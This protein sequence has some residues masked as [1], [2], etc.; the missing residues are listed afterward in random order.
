MAE[1]VDQFRCRGIGM[2]GWH[3]SRQTLSSFEDP[4]EAFRRRGAHFTF[5]APAYYQFIQSLRSPT[6]ADQAIPF[7]T[8]SHSLK[9]P[10][11][12]EQPIEP[13]D[14]LVL[15]EGLYVLLDISPWSEAA[16][17]LDA[18]IW[19]EADHTLTR[20]RL[21]RRHI[22]TGV[23]QTAS[24]AQNRVDGSDMLNAQFIQD[25][26]IKTD[27]T[28]VHVKSEGFDGEGVER[29]VCFQLDAS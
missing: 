10:S 3:H 4:E 26:L 17:L 27:V 18:K 8:F 20:E 23:E 19:I 14:D 29:N 11:P 1:T 13:S 21:I 5:D 25:R 28:V 24:A 16:A 2:D 15:I 22:E 7:P 6:H 9:D 12:S